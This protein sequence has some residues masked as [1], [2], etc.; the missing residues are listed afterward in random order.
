M[1]LNV[2]E[3][4]QNLVETY[5]SLIGLGYRNPFLPILQ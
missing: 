2:K 1:A 3:K 4:C 5:D